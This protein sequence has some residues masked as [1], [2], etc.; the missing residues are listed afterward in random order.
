MSGIR[1]ILCV[2]GDEK[3]GV[4]PLKTALLLAKD[5]ACHVEAFHVL[6]DA[7]S[8]VPYVGEAMAGALVE[9]MVEAAEKDARDRAD[10]AKLLFTATCDAMGVPMGGEPPGDGTATATWE[11]ARGPEPEQVALRGRVADMIVVGQPGPHGEPPSLLTLNAALM[12]SGRPV[13]V[14]PPA[15]PASL[16]KRV[17]IAWNGSAEAARA[18]VDALPFLARAERVTILMAEEKDNFAETSELERHL[19][20]HGISSTSQV[21]KAGPGTRPGEALVRAAEGLE[22]DLLVMGAY[23]HSRLRQL[24]MGGVTRYVLEHARFPVLL[25]H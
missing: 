20:W 4:V 6:V 8:A 16:G 7:A 5:S 24:I 3:S 10:K 11:E 23:T 1:T 19:A 14:S 15:V 18:V 21:L 2:V 17:A 9:E 12:E 25:T 13:L 22:A